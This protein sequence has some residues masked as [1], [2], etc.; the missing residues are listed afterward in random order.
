MLRIILTRLHAAWP[1]FAVLAATATASRAAI[2]TDALAGFTRTSAAPLS[3]SNKALWDEYGLE[4]AERAQYQSPTGKFSATAWRVK[5]S[6]CALAA[7]DGL[8][9]A[10]A[11][12]SKVWELALETDDGALVAFGNYVLQF[13]GWK[14]KPGELDLF[15]T[16]LPKLE[17]APLPKDYLPPAGLVANS[18]RYVLGPAGLDKYLPWISPSLA[19]FSMGAEVQ[20]GTFRAAGGEMQMSVFSYP[21]PQIARQKIEEFQKL[22]G[23]RARRNGPLI[24]VIRGARDPDAAER[25]LAEVRY[26]ASVTL[27]QRL[28]TRRDN[29]GDLIVNIFV[30]IGIL[31]SLFI[32]A[33]LSFGFLRRWAWA[34]KEGEAMTVLHLHDK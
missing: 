15:L 29:V 20:I 5:D 18:Q 22:A 26:Q 8:R 17:Q 9:P 34:G 30:L 2:W 11:R 10:N 6:T 31:L 16:R 24:A 28:P 13:D 1:L 4:Q 32:V 25:L 19:A 23:V 3:V 12:P 7:F 33:G 14:P 27:D 21:T